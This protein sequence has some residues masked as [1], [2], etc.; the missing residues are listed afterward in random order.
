M[1]KIIYITVVCFFTLQTNAQI[2]G[3]NEVP[4]DYW[5]STQDM[6]GKYFK[7]VN[8]LLDA[9]K[10]VWQWI[11]GNRELTFYL[12]IDEEVEMMM[13]AGN[14]YR[15]VVYGYYVYKEGGV[16]LIDTKQELLNS[17]NARRDV[18]RGG[19][20]LTPYNTGYNHSTLPALFFVDY[21]KRTCFNGVQRAVKGGPGLWRFLSAS[22]A[23]VGLYNAGPIISDCPG[24]SL[25][26]DLYPNFPS[27]STITLTRI[28]TQ[29][30]PLD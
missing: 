24:S 12:Y 30:P 6:V 3:Q 8:N 15:D 17:P 5:L 28:A 22:A 23:R 7:D 16:T 2:L 10:G 21:S 27:N 20:G 26:L 9:Y 25:I 29:A 18:S 11:D 19:I 14:H 13:F 4:L 1:K